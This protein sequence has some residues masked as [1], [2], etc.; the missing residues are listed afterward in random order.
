MYNTFVE[1]K[2]KKLLII[3]E[4]LNKVSFLKTIDNSS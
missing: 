2:H 3:F 4:F 1:N